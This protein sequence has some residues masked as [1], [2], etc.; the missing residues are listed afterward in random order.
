MNYFRNT[1]SYISAISTEV[2]Y[3]LKYRPYFH[4]NTDI[5]LKTYEEED[6]WEYPLFIL[7][8]GL[9]S[10]PRQYEH[11]VEYLKSTN[12]QADIFIPQIVDRGF[13]TIDVCCDKIMEG[14]MDKIRVERKI[15]IVGISNG[16]R[17]GMMLYK[18]IYEL[19]NLHTIY[20]TT[21][22]SPLY[23]TRS[24]SIIK[25]NN[26]ERITNFRKHKGI[27][28]SFC[29]NNEICNDL[30]EHLVNNVPDF[31]K[32]TRLYASNHDLVVFPAKCATIE[33]CD[34]VIVDGI[35]HDGLI[36]TFL[37]DQIDWCIKYI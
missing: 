12:I 11:H 20:F 4:T 1:Y 30:V 9:N 35:G 25:N 36:I 37:R 10:S 15:F 2:N 34:N 8:H 14:L 6:T 19:N 13:G 23:G 29:E 21:L 17:I 33:G 32:R 28:D 24:A 22:G 16:G 7:L 26:L 18:R 27:I 5:N 3:L 31:L